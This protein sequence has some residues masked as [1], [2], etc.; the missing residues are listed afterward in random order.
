MVSQK[1][2]R[3]YFIRLCVLILAS[4]RLDNGMIEAHAVEFDLDVGSPSEVV[5]A[6]HDKNL[7]FPFAMSDMPAQ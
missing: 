5:A 6:V 4:F 7:E 2:Q 3:S 1:M